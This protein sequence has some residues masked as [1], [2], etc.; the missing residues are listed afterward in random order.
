S[1]LEPQIFKLDNLSCS[2]KLRQRSTTSLFLDQRILTA[3]SV[4]NPCEVIA[5][6]P[7]LLVQFWDWLV[8][9]GVAN[10]ST[11]D[12]LPWHAEHIV[13]TR[14]YGRKPSIVSG[15]SRKRVIVESLGKDSHKHLKEFHGAR[16]LISNMVGLEVVEIANANIVGVVEVVAVQPPLPSIVQLL[17]PPIITANKL[18]AE[19]KERMLRDLKKLG[20]FYEH[21]TLHD[22]FLERF[23]TGFDNIISKQLVRVSGATGHYWTTGHKGEAYGKLE[24]GLRVFGI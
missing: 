21:L 11:L 1:Y 3:F 5:S 23:D 4:K 24:K 18:Q 19:Q 14:S 9:L 16:N 17:Q 12:H 20:D 22:C 15:S 8:D 13:C 10:P 7:T 6:T 2:G